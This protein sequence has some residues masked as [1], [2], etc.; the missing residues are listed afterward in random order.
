[1]GMAGEEH[2]AWRLSSVTLNE[3]TQKISNRECQSVGLIISY[4]PVSSWL[5]LC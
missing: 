1:M 3:K 4:V 5:N 2:E